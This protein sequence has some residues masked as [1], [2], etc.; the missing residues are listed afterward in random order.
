MVRLRSKDI[1][2]LNNSI[3]RPK[4]GVT[5][6][7]TFGSDPYVFILISSLTKFIYHMVNLIVVEK[8][9]FH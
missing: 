4:D 8:F 5:S 6:R 3:L 9:F 7:R 2:I 1:K